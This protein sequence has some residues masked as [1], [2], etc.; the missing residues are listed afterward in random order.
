MRV[1]ALAG[2]KQ[3]GE[4]LPRSGHHATCFPAVSRSGCFPGVSTT[5]PASWQWAG[6]ELLPGSE[7][8]ATCFL[9]VST[10]IASGELPDP[11]RNLRRPPPVG[12]L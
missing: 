1:S 6:A 2:R 10:D 5:R 11:G 9:G 4:L 7:H 12:Q 3:V 8:H